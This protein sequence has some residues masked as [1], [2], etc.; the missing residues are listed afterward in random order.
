MLGETKRD[1]VAERRAAT[2]REILDAAWAQARE[3]GIANIT[4]RDIAREVGMQPPS[5]YSHFD[6]KNAVYD[7]MYAEAWAEYEAH[8]LA[9]LDDV[10]AHP[11]AAIHRAGRVFFDFAVADLARH[12]L[13]NQR[14][15]PG[16]EPTAEA[17]APAVRVLDH[18]IA[19]LASQGVTERA[20][21]DIWISLIGGLIDQQLANDPGGDRFSRLLE[22]AIDMFADAVGMPPLPQK[23]PTRRKAGTPR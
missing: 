4:L 2:R 5:L 8:A 17:Y 12:Q 19:F 21:F 6:S 20:D 11:R 3:V 10:P 18:G 7:A 1:R 14:T 22:R 16:F 23:H 15:I 13:M 9:Q